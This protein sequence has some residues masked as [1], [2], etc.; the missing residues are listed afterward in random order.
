M[1]DRRQNR[2]AHPR[3]AECFAPSELPR[4]RQAADDLCWL[5]SRGYPGKAAL[6][7]VGDRYA[8]RDR[9]RMAIQR[10]TVGEPTG[11]RRAGR[12]VGPAE[13]RGRPL[14]V[15]GYNVLLTVETAL[16]G[17]VVLGSRDG[18]F[19]DMASMH[20]HYK[21][22]DQ[23]RPA[24][25][26]IGAFLAAAPCREVAWYLDRPVS[27][28]GRLK[29]W[30]EEEAADHGW[31][32]TVE[33]VASPDRVLA[34]GREIVATADGWILDQCRSWVSLARRVIEG[35]VPEAWVVDL[36]GAG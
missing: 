18:A 3:D 1:P 34:E 30:M 17:G 31:P 13:L 35:A 7:L 32:W 15:D 21:R 4:L 8:L 22:V 6:G 9:Q 12:E 29:Q 14:A 20:R 24:L 28:S 5:L 2:G 27:N 19:R 33:L 26:A 25:E 36:S 23:T 16:G 11:A 10:A